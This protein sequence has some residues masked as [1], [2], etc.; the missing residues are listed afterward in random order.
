[1]RYVLN[2][3][4]SVALIWNPRFTPLCLREAKCDKFKFEDVCVY[5]YGCLVLFVFS[6]TF[7]YVSK[8]GIILLCFGSHMYVYRHSR[9]SSFTTSN[10]DGIKIER[11]IASSGFGWRQKCVTQSF[12]WL[13]CCLCVSY[14]VC[15]HIIMHIWFGTLVLAWFFVLVHLNVHN[16][17]D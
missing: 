5:L 6:F 2:L 3:Q 13:S 4:A 11:F 15:L 1:M 9:K 7:F 16:K 14:K 10:W 12:W 8:H 17:I